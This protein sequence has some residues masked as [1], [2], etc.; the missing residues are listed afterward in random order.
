MTEPNPGIFEDGRE[1]AMNGAPETEHEY[2][3][4]HLIFQRF[5]WLSGYAAGLGLLIEFREQN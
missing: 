5:S 1:A 2:V 4:A 3:D